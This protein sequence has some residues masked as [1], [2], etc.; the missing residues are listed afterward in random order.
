MYYHTLYF[1]DKSS[2]L[3]LTYRIMH[4]IY[5]IYTIDTNLKLSLVRDATNLSIFY[6]NSPVARILS[7]SFFYFLL[8]IVYYP[9]GII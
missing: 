1:K 2:S 6:H 5:N 7:S 9:C 8:F 4:G 3:L